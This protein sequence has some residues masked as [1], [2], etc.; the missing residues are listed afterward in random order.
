MYYNKVYFADDRSDEDIFSP[1]VVSAFKILTDENYYH[2]TDDEERA[3][4]PEETLS[5]IRCVAGGGKIFTDRGEFDI[6]ENE[7]IILPF[8]HI[9]K[10]KST[11]RVFGY[12]W[13][14]FLSHGKNMPALYTVFYSTVTDEEEK[15][16][17]K[18]LLFGNNYSNKSYADFLFTDYYYRVTAKAEI[19]S[20]LNKK[21]S[22]NRQIDDICSYV[23]Q[24][25]FTKLTVDELSAFFDISPRRLHQIFTEQL[26][27][28]PKQ[29]ILKKKM[30]EGY[31]LLVQ[32]SMPVNKIADLLCFSSAY[33][34][35][36]EFGKT[37]GMTPTSVRNME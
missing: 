13:T 19:D 24:K 11:R 36:N 28:S 4:H 20:V 21:Q 18:F 2:R 31:R 14:N 25:V 34:F 3:Y 27:I 26:G 37:F 29:F 32:T 7:Y 5:F 12:R 33:H 35:T 22:S 6:S 9:T 8:S 30:E 1:A 17:D 10:Y 23:V 16:F 15:A